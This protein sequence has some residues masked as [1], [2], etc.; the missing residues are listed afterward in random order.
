MN[1]ESQSLLVVDDNPPSRDGLS[2]LLEAHGYAVTVGKDGRAALELTGRQPFD[3]VLLDVMMAGLNGLDVL[4]RLRQSHS[5][6][7]LPVIMTT[8]RGESEDIVE[9][10]K[11]GANDYV[12]KPI[13]FPVL[14][15]RIQTQLSLK[16]AVRRIERL[17]QNLKERNGELEVANARMK[18][19][20]EAAA[21]IQEAFLPPRVLPFGGVNSSW[22]FRPCTHLAGDMLNVFP[23]D[24]DHLGLY[25]LDV[26]GHGVAAALLSVTLSHLLAPRLDPSSLLTQ[27]ER[28]VSPAKVAERL[29]ARF[30]WDPATEQYFTLVYGILNRKTGR[31]RYVSAGHPG[32]VLVPRGGPPRLVERPSLPIGVGDG[33]YDEH[34]L[35]LGRGDRLYLYTDGVIEALNSERAVFGKQRLLEA[36]D[37]LRAAPLQDGLEALW[38]DVEQWSGDG[39][40]RDDVSILA[41]ELVE[42]PARKGGPASPRHREA[43][44][45]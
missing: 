33:N 3:L 12:T 2:H 38:G 34:T 19:D 27:G 45:P 24:G 29:N 18:L 36:V 8:A 31:L 37:G 17:E 14:L 4:Q 26:S 41:V 5:V 35:T 10:L 13:D 44:S 7:D 9:A 40:R 43:A 16:H 28:L 42:S 11:L 1:S 25:V 22:V 21:R 6:T 20:L 15:A 30:P 32:P 39:R 23:L